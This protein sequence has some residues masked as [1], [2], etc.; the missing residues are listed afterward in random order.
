MVVKDLSVA[1]EVHIGRGDVVEGFV[2][3]LVVVKVGKRLNY[4]FQVGR[5]VVVIKTDDIFERAVVA[6]DFTLCHGM[7]G[8]TANMSELLLLEEGSQVAGQKGKTVV[9]QQAWAMVDLSVLNPAEGEGFVESG[10][11]VA[12]SHAG[13]ER[14][15]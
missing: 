9:G 7:E 5:K 4:L 2:V 12:S 15:S 10:L 1:L 6:L 14:P 3:A 11:H 8:F 13:V